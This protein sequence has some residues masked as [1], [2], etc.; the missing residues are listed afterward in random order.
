[1]SARGARRVEDR[2][3]AADGSGG[4]LTPRPGRAYRSCVVRR[5]HDAVPA[6]PGFRAA[7]RDRRR[8]Q[9]RGAGATGAIAGR[10]AARLGGVVAV[11]LTRGRPGL[12]WR[13][14]PRRGGLMRVGVLFAADR[15]VR[16]AGRPRRRR[17]DGPASQ[18]RQQRRGPE[19]G[20]A[21]DGG[22]HRV[23]SGEGSRAPAN[24]GPGMTVPAPAPA[25]KRKPRRFCRRRAPRKTGKTVAIRRRPGIPS[26]FLQGRRP[27]AGGGRRTAA[28]AGD[29]EP[30]AGPPHF[31]RAPPAFRRSSR[32]DIH[33]RTVTRRSPCLA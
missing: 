8:R 9:R 32:R 33:V 17:R 28:F 23:S 4:A 27:A 14:R 1:M 2:G 24:A 3:R 20:P 6:L 5:A 25:S 21:S 18:Q 11:L 13:G 19:R 16:P 22:S 30:T 10:D 12:R 15:D 26:F 7:A 29:S 31:T